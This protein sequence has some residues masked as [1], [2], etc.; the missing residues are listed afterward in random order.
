MTR[1]SPFHILAAI[2]CKTQ[3][4]SFVATDDTDS[5]SLFL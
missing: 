2:L 3:G 4:I 5:F 1:L